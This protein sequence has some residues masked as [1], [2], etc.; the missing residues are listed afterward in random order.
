MSTVDRDPT[1]CG[2]GV[3]PELLATGLPPVAE[4]PGQARRS[5]DYSGAELAGIA[6]VDTGPPPKDASHAQQHPDSL[7][8][9]SLG[10]FF[11]AGCPEY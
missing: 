11:L 3:A 1:A 4:L 8:H 5:S 2:H 9:A 7:E 6:I 10:C